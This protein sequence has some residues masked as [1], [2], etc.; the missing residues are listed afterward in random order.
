M[1]YISVMS[2]TRL[3]ALLLLLILS[4]LAFAQGENKMWTF[5][6]HN[7]LNFNNTPP[8]FFLSSNMS[9]EG[10]A[11]VASASGS[12]LFYSNGNNV[13]NASGAVMPNGSG[14]LGNGA[15]P[16]AITGSS[17]QGVAIV[18]SMSNS[19]QYYLFTLDALEQ[20]SLSY[21]GYLRYSVIDMSLNGGTGD[22][23]AGQ[24]N[25]V[26]DSFMSEKMTITKGA[27]CSYWLLTHRWN[28]PTYLAF[29]I[30]A[31]GVQPPVS[32][33]GT[34]QGS[35]SGG[36]LKV[37]FDGTRIANSVEYGVE[38]GTFNNATGMVSNTATMDSLPGNGHFGA[39]F[40]PDDQKLYIG[41][42][43]DLSQYDMSA[44]PNI[45]AV[46][47]SKTIIS[48]PPSFY[49]FG[50]FR[51]GPDGKIYVGFMA[52]YPY[53][54]VINAPNNNGMACNLNLTGLTQ[55]ASALGPPGSSMGLGNDI[56]IN[57][58]TEPDTIINSVTDT[59]LCFSDSYV[60][61]ASGVSSSYLWNDGNTNASRILTMD[62]TYWVYGFQ[63]C[64]MVVVDTFKVKFVKL[65]VSLG[66]D[67][68]ICPGDSLL[69]DASHPGASY[70][71][72]DNSNSATMKVTGS[73]MYSVTITKE[74][75]EISDSIAVAMID[76]NVLIPEADTTICAG[77]NFT[78]HAVSTQESNYN[79]S[80]GSTQANITISQ[81]GVYTVIASNI[82]GI[83]TDSIT[84]NTKDCQCLAFVPNVFSPNEDGK[85]DRFKVELGC[86][87]TSF[88]LSIYNRYGQRIYQAN[89]QSASWDGFYN[90]QYADA[91][92]YFYYL[93]YKNG[94]GTTIEKKGDVTLLR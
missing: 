26:L 89:D 74:G 76:P 13:W 33:T 16:G 4:R 9:F 17:A 50:Q 62:G 58:A 29:K 70:Q 72:Q 56:V 22:V 39:A 81:A 61:T 49:N 47:A 87:T 93:Q 27:D 84:I 48:L 63:N 40:S 80:N 79:W 43:A 25:I 1:Q 91:G 73:G 75:C 65:N 5:G 68:A 30:T 90:G 20:I 57:P 38:I 45:A 78:L 69:L 42:N 24:K 83:Y 2:R 12:L 85:N 64:G 7:G 44:Y 19:D 52:N 46:A 10:C 59:V 54:A 55:P 71:W 35:L 41:S 31:A 82:C 51:N 88:K 28:S 34:W 60:A 8:T 15:Y 14:I 53:I 86:S 94:F 21:P 92:T 36:Q 66:S 77:E 3:V 18:K 67:T 32:S 6:I 23:V 11:S 37:S